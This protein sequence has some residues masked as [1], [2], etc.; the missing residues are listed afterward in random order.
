MSVLEPLDA[1]RDG[2]ALLLS[3][4][5]ALAIQLPIYDRWLSLLDEGAIAQIADQINHG[6]PPY[7]YAVHLALPGVFYLTAGLYQLFG[8]SFL[9][10]RIFMLAIFVA[11]VACIY[12]LA[13]SVAGRGVA[14]GVTLLAVAYRLWAF[15]HWQMISY[16]PMAILCLMLCVTLL[17]FDLARPRPWLPPV[18]GLL[19]G[20]GVLF[21]Q[22]VSGVTAVVLA[23]F[24][25]LV[26]KRRSGRW[27]AALARVLGF[28]SAALSPAALVVLAF[29]ADGLAEE[30]L[31]QTIWVPLVAK[32][33]WA[34]VTTEVPYL[35]FPPIWPPWAA[36]DEI[37]GRGLFAY[38]PSL[39]L[40]LYW[41]EL[42]L[43]PLF[44]KS[45]LPELFVRAVY[46][47]PPGLLAVFIGRECALG[48]GRP[49]AADDAAA[50]ERLWLLLAFGV[51][52]LLSFNRPRDWVH[53]MIL[54]APTLIL[55]APLMEWLRG[56]APGLRRR[57]LDAAGMAFVALALACSFALAAAARNAYAVP[58]EHPR[59]RLSERAHVAAVV[60]PLI[61]DLTPPRGEAPAALAAL[62]AIPALNFITG[63]PLA[64]RFLTLLPLEEYPDRD[65]QIVSELAR[66]P[67][68]DV[69]YAFAQAGIFARPQDYAP[70][71]FAFLTQHYELRAG[72]GGVYDGTGPGGL[73]LA[74]LRPRQAAV[75]T[76]LYDFAAHLDEAQVEPKAP[77][78]AAGPPWPAP[79]VDVWPFEAPVVAVTP[80]PPPAVH[81]LQ[82]EIELEAPARLRFGVAMDPDTWASFL[83]YSLHFAVRIDGQ[84]VFRATLDPRRRLSDRR[85]AWQELPVAAGRHTIR[86]ETRTDSPLGAVAAFAGWARPRLVALEAERAS[87][88]GAAALLSCADPSIVAPSLRE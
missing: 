31:Y 73:L 55:L 2:C 80:P 77:P 45:V 26:W 70:G 64:T 63:R 30:L 44:R 65:A 82:Y 85:Y 9:V 5:A 22:D 19:L 48:L 54:Y 68:L 24:L 37:R 88:S 23:P 3:L 34:Q 38:F 8:T 1:R 56:R 59:V 18:A 52:L 71:V 84:P 53:L 60:E 79:R 15:P 46:L 7:R 49:G 35:G 66:H 69:V 39:P 21:K 75:E 58:I 42:I 40:D 43:H 4:A 29:A 20:V 16:T 51:A 62:P 17:S 81:T 32:P 47:L 87:A 11:F 12:L 76:L 13:R 6:L 86:F 36:S 27:R 74:R 28:G 50:R 78:A 33:I 72:P 10:G 67:G 41:Q 57:F 25:L 61:R 14:L 83:I